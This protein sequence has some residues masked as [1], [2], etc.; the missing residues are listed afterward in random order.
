VGLEVGIRVGL[1]IGAELRLAVPVKV[2]R[3]TAVLVDVWEGS[4]VDV[5]VEAGVPVGV[6]VC[7]KSDVIEGNGREIESGALPCRYHCQN[8]VPAKSIMTNNGSNKTI[9][10]LGFQSEIR[11]C[12]SNPSLEITGVFG[13]S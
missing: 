5:G 11:L 10:N 7:F 3:M 2:G 4:K 12:L 8:K 9:Y 13:P 6:L 1:G